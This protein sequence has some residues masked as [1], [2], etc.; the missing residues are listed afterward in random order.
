MKSRILFSSTWWGWA[1][2]QACRRRERSGA[3]AAGPGSATRARARARAKRP[4]RAVGM[5]P[6]KAIGTAVQNGR[7]GHVRAEQSGPEPN[8]PCSRSKRPY[9]I[10]CSRPKRPCIKRLK[11]PH[12]R[13]PPSDRGRGRPR[14]N[15]ADPHAAQSH[16]PSHV[17]LGDVACSPRS[18]RGRARAAPRLAAQPVTPDSVSMTQVPCRRLSA[19]RSTKGPLTNRRFVN[20]NEATRGRQSES[21]GLGSWNERRPRT[22]SQ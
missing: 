1:A 3:E 18:R 8:T 9:K 22:P 16:V 10:D 12:K 6:C 13:P 19:N 5:R 20:L 11:R 14:S 21:G 4:G 7:N 2:S 15:R 17:R